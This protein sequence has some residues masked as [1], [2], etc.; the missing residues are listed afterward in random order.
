MSFIERNEIQNGMF[1]A[2]FCHCVQISLEIKFI[3]NAT[4]GSA[5][6]ATLVERF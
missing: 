5:L 4:V 6:R 1:I 2:K 3:R